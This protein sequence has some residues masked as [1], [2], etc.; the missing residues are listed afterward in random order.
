MA[1]PGVVAG[2]R[3]TYSAFSRAFQFAAMRPDRG[4]VLLGLA[5]APDAGLGLAA[6]KR[7]IWSERLTSEIRLG[8]A[9][10]IAPLGAAI[11][12]AWDNS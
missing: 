9:G 8:S 1:L 7:V 5:V 12:Q 11:R 4:A 2:Q 10:E 3:K 6:P